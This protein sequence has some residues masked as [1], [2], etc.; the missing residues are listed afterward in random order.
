[1]ACIWNWFFTTDPTFQ[2]CYQNKIPFSIQQKV[3]K[4]CHCLVS[5]QS[6][7]LFF[8]PIVS[9]VLK[10]R[11]FQ[12][13]SVGYR[14]Q[15]GIRD[16]FL[17]HWCATQS[18]VPITSFRGN[19]KRMNKT[20]YTTASIMDTPTIAIVSW[21]IFQVPLKERVDVIVAMFSSQMYQ[22]PSASFASPCPAKTAIA[23][24]S[25]RRASPVLKI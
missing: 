5:E 3:L 17:E 18:A 16:Q 23:D 22:D 12:N 6:P 19:W 8:D 4:I 25:A 2:E 15:L 9:C 1:M 11:M 14:F 10:S 13:S 24:P 7:F 20:G 21:N